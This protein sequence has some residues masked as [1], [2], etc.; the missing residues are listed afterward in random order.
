MR[1]E[2]W[3]FTIRVT[4]VG[5]D[6]D[7]AWEDAQNSLALDSHIRYDGAHLEYVVDDDDEEAT[8]D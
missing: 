7:Q 3:V 1:E 8:N 5:E 6:K 4:G 2:T